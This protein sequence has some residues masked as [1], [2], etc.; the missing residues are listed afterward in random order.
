MHY[1]FEWDKR[2][3]SLVYKLQPWFCYKDACLK[4]K[5]VCPS[6]LWAFHSLPEARKDCGGEV[7]GQKHERDVEETT[8]QCKAIH[9]LLV[10][11]IYDWLGVLDGRRGHVSG[12]FV[13]VLQSCKTRSWLIFLHTESQQW[14]LRPHPSPPLLPYWNKENTF[15]WGNICKQAKCGGKT[16]VK[17]EPDSYV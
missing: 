11:L 10:N 12:R 1:P 16:N 17:S 2:T 4:I 7:T 9:G 15:G 3:F 6:S 14:L 8:K 13:Y 5:K